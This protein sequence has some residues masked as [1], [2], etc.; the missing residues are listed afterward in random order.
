[1]KKIIVLLAL[2]LIAVSS[3]GDDVT[4]RTRSRNLTQNQPVTGYYLGTDGRW[5]AWKQFSFTT[6]VTTTTTNLVTY[7]APV[8]TTQVLTNFDGVST[9]NVFTNITAIAWT[10]QTNAVVKTVSA[11]TVAQ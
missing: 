7:V 4:E 5:N 1:M 11:T 2:A 3:F 6:T 9:T 8:Y 10:I